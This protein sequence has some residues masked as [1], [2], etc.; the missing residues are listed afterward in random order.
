MPDGADL[1]APRGPRNPGVSDLPAPRGGVARIPDRPAP[2]SSVSD[3]PAPAGARIPPIR[4]IPS[5]SAGV[6]D[7]PAPAGRSAGGISDLPAPAGRP[8]ADGIVDLPAPAGARG[9]ANLPAP[10]GARGISDLPAPAGHPSAGITD[11]PA[12]AGA[13]GISDLPTPAGARGISD[14]PAPAGIADLPAPRTGAGGIVDLPSPKPG[15]VSDVPAPKGFFDDL[16]QPVSGQ[17]SELP[18][19]KGFFEDLPQPATGGGPEVPA[20]K[21]FFDDLPQPS[22]GGNAPQPPAPKGF[23]DDLPQPATGAQ[24]PAP[25]GFFDDLPQPGMSNAPEAPAPK[26]FFDDLPQPTPPAGP[27]PG[28]PGRAKKPSNLPV[29]LNFDSSSSI[30]LGIAPDSAPNAGGRFDNLD[31]SKPTAPDPI[32]FKTPTS[33]PPTAPTAPTRAQRRSLQPPT[34]QVLELE[35]PRPTTQPLRPLPPREADREVDPDAHR[36]R[37]RRIRFLALGGLLVVALGAGGFYVYRRWDAKQTTARLIDS[38]LAIARKAMA[39]SDAG[40]WNRAITAVAAVLEAD[41][42]NGEALAI[43]AE[44]R[45]ASALADGVGAP[46]KLAMARRHIAKAVAGHIAGPQLIRAQALSA[47]AGGDGARGVSLLEPQAKSAKDAQL[48]LYLGWAYRTGGDDENAIKAF[49]QAADLGTD[50]IKIHALYERGQTK[51]SM[52]DLEGAKADFD[53]VLALDKTHVGAQIG[54]AAAMPAARSQDQEKQLLALL[55]ND[56][57]TAG[58]DPRALVRAWTLIAETAVRGNRLD[59]ARERYRKALAL[60][61]DD[62]GALAGL[63]DVELRDGKI[64]LARDQV[65]RAIDI[66][67]N[68]IR[69]QLVQSAV[70]LASDDRDDARQRVQALANR[71]PP[72]PPLDQARIKMMEGKLAELDGDDQAALADYREAAKLAGDTDLSPTLL[73]V[74]KLG[75]LADAAENDGNTDKAQEYRDTAD[76]MLAKLE[77][78]A[79]ADP[80]LALT[81][82][83]AY[84]RTN[85]AAKAEPWLRKYVEA[86]PEEPEGE[87]QLA[88]ALGQLGQ[89]DAAINRLIKARSMAPERSEI[90]IELARTYERADQD[91]KAA[92]VYEDLLKNTKDPGVEL[93]ARAGKFFARRGEIDKAAEQG[94]KILAVAPDHLIGKYLKGEGEL[95]AGNLDEARKLFA[96]AAAEH[97]PMYLDALGRANEAKFAEASDAKY[98]QQAIDNYST[99]IKLDP[100]MFSAHLGLGRVLIKRKEY[101]AAIQPLDEAWNIKHDPK[102]AY[103]MGVAYMEQRNADPTR[104]KAAIASLE[105]ATE[106]EPKNGEAQYRLGL[107]YG[108]VNKGREAANRLGRAVAIGEKTELDS[109]ANTVPWL[110]DALFQLGEVS[111][112]NNDLRGA[113]HAWERYLAR[114]LDTEYHRQRAQRALA[115]ELKGIN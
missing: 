40:H 78:N 57:L 89:T 21:G 85:D 94:A 12:P 10:A 63:A 92:E 96:A 111:K 14:L 45:I 31:L 97:D 56:K 22:T 73:A 24:A 53:A 61:P 67:P 34:D 42:D 105:T 41:E 5:P 107:L 23:F 18:A 112:S 32:R 13:R 55:A 39:A 114:P 113:K 43:S 87:Y 33:P 62:V 70:S 50:S 74:E 44:A 47:I 109:G 84:V 88:K 19:P 9:I 49:G 69:A 110:T 27:T 46:T 8:G 68:D 60:I 71:N 101:A 76:K 52:V 90:G 51:L 108:E 66:A 1:P 72:P 86:R 104:T 28:A 20:P 15:G 16:P 29:E 103:L 54:L 38:Q 30:D 17:A 80:Q 93:R 82:G 115:T 59:A 36:R 77:A 3:L 35:E 37:A 91:D 2:T 95:K 75:K 65:K 7:L 64:D 102:I 106:L 99:A 98:A 79:G 48:F 11:L 81:L 25:Q 6:S 4:P 83:I 58:A 100:K 26:G